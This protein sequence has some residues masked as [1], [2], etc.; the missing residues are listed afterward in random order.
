MTTVM[1]AA[2]ATMGFASLLR[3]ASLRRFA[4]EGTRWIPA[5]AGMTRGVEAHR[6]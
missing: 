4:P 5:F 6:G 2:K 3:E 1:E